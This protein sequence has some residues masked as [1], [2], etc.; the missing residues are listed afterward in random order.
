MFNALHGVFLA[1][2]VSQTQAV[3]LKINNWCNTQVKVVLSHNGG[4]DYG[5]NGQC[6]TAGSQPWYL[7]PSTITTF[8]FINDGQGT[9]VKISKSG[10]GNGIL[11]F[12]YAVVSGQCMFLNSF[13]IFSRSIK[14]ND[15]RRWNLLGPIG[16]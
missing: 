2:L 8:G 4:C 16:S 5:T 9:S 11:Q 7:N 10:Q 6:I 14:A 3:S 15:V 13:F 1:A 12:E